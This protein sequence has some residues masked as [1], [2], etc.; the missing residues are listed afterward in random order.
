ML[1][2]KAY[3][4]SCVEKFLSTK[5]MK[6]SGTICVQKKKK[7]IGSLKSILSSTQVQITYLNDFQVG[8]SNILYVAL[9]D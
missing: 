4:V 1:E 3:A 6:C 5:S 2:L 8:I 9:A 7:K